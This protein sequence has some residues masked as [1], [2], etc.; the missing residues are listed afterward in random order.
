MHSTKKLQHS[1]NQI[2]NHIESKITFK[3]IEDKYN[4]QSVNYNAINNL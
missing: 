2:F 3:F 4:T 1:S